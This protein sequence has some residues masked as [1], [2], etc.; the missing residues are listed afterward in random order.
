MDSKKLVECLRILVSTLNVQTSHFNEAID[1]LEQIVAQ[2]DERLER[3]ERFF[4]DAKTEF[5]QDLI[6]S[7]IALYE[8]KNR[9][10]IFK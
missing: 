4:Q 8:K 3:Y 9:S 10:G 5:F 7:E 2:Q 6:K 1:R